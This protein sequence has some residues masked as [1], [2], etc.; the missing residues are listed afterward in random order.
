LVNVSAIVSSDVTLMSNSN[1]NELFIINLATVPADRILIPCRHKC[2]AVTSYFNSAVKHLSAATIILL[3]LSCSTQQN[4]LDGKVQTEE[5][6]YIMWAC[7]CA[8]W[9]TQDVL[10]QYQDTGKLSEHCVFVEPASKSLILPDTLGYS[11]DIVQFTGQYYVERGYPNDY[12]KGEQQV[13]KAK[14]F[15]Y[16]AYKIIKSN[17]REF[18]NDKDK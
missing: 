10:T 1:N 5:F 6:H 12:V 17:Y 8:N 13:D 11:G 18:V 2:V 4:K 7:E 15:R 9:A 14:V 3:L 16:T